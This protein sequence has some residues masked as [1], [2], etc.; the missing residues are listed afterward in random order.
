[1]TT[2]QIFNGSYFY[3]DEGITKWPSVDQGPNPFTID[4][5]KATL[6]NNNY[7][8][9]IWT[10]KNLQLTVMSIPPQ[11]DIGLEVHHDHDQ[12]L[13]VEDGQGLVTMG[14]RRDNLYYQ[15]Y[16]FDDTAV[17]V[18]AGTWHNIINTGNKPLKVY[19]IYAP[20]QHE[21]GTIHA[22]KEIAEL[23]ENHP[24]LPKQPRIV[25]YYPYR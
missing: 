11:T 21:H 14:N 18:P 17:F 4:I 3:R 24:N 2:N 1:M 22:T 5:K 25:H 13:R 12:F 6:E 19:S 8:T 20:P 9:T 16:A 10:G 23:E 7:R 15:Q